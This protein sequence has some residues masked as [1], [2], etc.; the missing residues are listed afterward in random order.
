[1]QLSIS[2]IKED[3][4]INKSSVCTLRTIESERWAKQ[5]YNV[6]TGTTGYLFKFLFADLSTVST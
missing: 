1:M 5:L 6:S 2:I 4:Y 3:Y